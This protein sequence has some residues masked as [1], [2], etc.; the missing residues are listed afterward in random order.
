ME[1]EQLVQRRRRN[2]ITFLNQKGLSLTILNADDSLW[3]LN[4]HDRIMIPQHK[5]T[6]TH[7]LQISRKIARILLHDEAAANWMNLRGKI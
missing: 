5:H 4:A 3:K 6:H 7:E 2:I 1:T